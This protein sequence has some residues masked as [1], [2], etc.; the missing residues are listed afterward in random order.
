MNN[1]AAKANHCLVEN[2]QYAEISPIKNKKIISAH[3]LTRAAIEANKKPS[4]INNSSGKDLINI[5]ILF[6]QSVLKNSILYVI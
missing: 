4:I 1:A 5:I 3:S 2:A 6:N